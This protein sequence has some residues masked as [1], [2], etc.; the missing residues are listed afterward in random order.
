MLD[1]DVHVCPLAII[2]PCDPKK[3]PFPPLPSTLMSEPWTD[4]LNISVSR[5][6]PPN[7]KC[8]F[9]FI[10]QFAAVVFAS[11]LGILSQQG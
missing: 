2:E 1:P 4:P 6:K 11:S 9:Y 3:T 8:S 5:P 7:V 10:F